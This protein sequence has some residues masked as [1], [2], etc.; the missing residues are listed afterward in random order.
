MEK[1]VWREW[2]SMENAADFAAEGIALLSG[3]PDAALRA[4]DCEAHGRGWR[5]QT[6]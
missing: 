5:P 6:E 2:L 3:G 4:L 1:T